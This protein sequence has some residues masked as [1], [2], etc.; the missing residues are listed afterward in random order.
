MPS[1]IDRS[2][3]FGEPV[4]T[5]VGYDVVATVVVVVVDAFDKVVDS[6]ASNVLKSPGTQVDGRLRRVVLELGWKNDA[7]G[8]AVKFTGKQSDG[9]LM[10]IAYNT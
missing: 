8:I 3:Q 9:A 4:V 6:V 10:K 2:T 7:A 1:Y 5:S